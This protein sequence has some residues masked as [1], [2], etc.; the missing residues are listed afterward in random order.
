M[1]WPSLTSPLTDLLVCDFNRNIDEDFE[2][3]VWREFLHLYFLKDQDGR[4][5]VRFDHKMLLY[6]GDIETAILYDV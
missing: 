6:C 1:K 3:E 2:R 4:E 5:Y